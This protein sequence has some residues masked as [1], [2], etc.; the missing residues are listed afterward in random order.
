MTEATPRPWE[1]RPAQIGQHVDSDG[2]RDFGIG[3]V[4]GD[5]NYCI[6]EAF[7]RVDQLTFAPAEANAALIV[8]AVNAHDALVEA[9]ADLLL[10]RSSGDPTADFE[11]RNSAFN[12]DTGKFMPG[13]DVPVGAGDLAGTLEDYAKWVSD[14]VSKARAA[15]TLAKRAAP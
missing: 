1:M 7:W 6:A 4:L 3:A 12:R 9:L 14:K 2:S 15:L 8:R 13:K 10:I 5:Q 11:R